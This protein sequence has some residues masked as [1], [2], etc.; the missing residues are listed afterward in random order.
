VSA[1]LEQARAAKKH[2]AAQLV[3]MYQVNGIGIVRDDGGYGLKVNLLDPSPSPRLPREVD[4]VKVSVD[5][6]GP[7]YAG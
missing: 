2:L 3:D 5:V 1:S 4:G 7:A 6:V